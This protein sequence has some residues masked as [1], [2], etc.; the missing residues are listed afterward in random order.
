MEISQTLGG[1]VDG[2]T[3]QKIC[4]QRVREKAEAYGLTADG[5]AMLRPIMSRCAGTPS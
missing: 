2:H 4:Q 1:T 5:A 3:V